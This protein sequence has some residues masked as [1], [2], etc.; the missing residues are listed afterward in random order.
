MKIASILTIWMAVLLTP[1][2]AS[3]ALSV[4]INTP[5]AVSTDTGTTI[6]W[7]SL[8][9]SGATETNGGVTRWTATSDGAACSTS[10]NPNCKT[11]ASLIQLTVSGGTND[12]TLK[13]SAKPASGSASGTLLDFVSNGTVTSA[14]NYTKG[15]T[16]TVYILMSDLCSKVFISAGNANLCITTPFYSP[17]TITVGVSNGTSYVESADVAIGVDSG[18][19]QT[20]D[21]SVPTGL[22]DFTVYEGDA[23]LKIKNISAYASPLAFPLENNSGSGIAYARFYYFGPSPGPTTTDFSTL[24]ARITAGTASHQDFAVSGTTLSDPTIKDLT[25]DVLYTVLPALIDRAGNIGYRGV[26]SKFTS[27]QQGRPGAVVGVLSAN[28]GCFIATAAFGSYENKWVKTLREFRD[29]ILLKSE[30]GKKFVA[31]YYRHSPA[32]ADSIRNSEAK[33]AVVRVALWPLIVLSFLML[34]FGAANGVLLFATLL[35]LPLLLYR[36]FTTPWPAPVPSRQR[37]KQSQRALM[38]WFVVLIAAALTVTRTASAQDVQPWLPQKR[39]P[40]T[41]S[42]QNLQTPEETAAAKKANRPQLMKISKEG[43]YIYKVKPSEQHHAAG[44][45]AGPYQPKNIVGNSGYDYNTIYGNSP[46]VL[47]D[48]DYEWQFFQK[49]GKLGLKPSVGFFSKKGQGQFLNRSAHKNDPDETFTLIV[50][51]FSASAI[52]RAQY[53]THQFFVP[54]GEVGGDHFSLLET[55]A[56]KKTIGDSVKT[57]GANGWHWAGGV[58]LQLDWLDRSSTW[59]LDTEYGINHIY[60]TFDVRQTIGLNIDYDF[61]ALTYEGGITFEF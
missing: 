10:L 24:D 59:N 23:K 50:F 17:G 37:R 6:Y 26:A 61:T 36:W 51:D 58:A 57:A 35:I 14:I 12:G 40:A 21:P 54:F 2:L 27:K 47:V 41:T 1:G 20:S 16:N 32:W 45:R 4:T 39:K 29:Q 34:K 11:V 18:I 13:W 48:V 43:T 25:N 22:Y 56:D 52:Y 53:W 28:Q 49:A 3:A 55:R 31:W 9:N 30:S 33:R 7:F 8:I 42:I 19:E 60:L 46:G 15:S 5:S 44:V 38:I